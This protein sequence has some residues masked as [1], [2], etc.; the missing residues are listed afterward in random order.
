MRIRSS[1]VLNM[2]AA[3]CL[4]VSV[5]AQQP[6][7]EGADV[8]AGGWDT[9][10]ADITVRHRRL[11]RDGTPVGL[12]PMPIRYRWQQSSG[13]AGARTVLTFAPQPKA[14]AERPQDARYEVA[15][16]EDDGD[17]TPPRIYN[18]RGE[19]MQ[20]PPPASLGLSGPARPLSD[21]AARAAEGPVSLPQPPAGT[22]AMGLVAHADDVGARRS[23]LK[24][25][26]GRRVERIG[27]LERF[28]RTDGDDTE[29]V[30]A[31]PESGLPTEV[32]IVRNGRLAWHGRFMYT[33]DR[34]GAYMRRAMHIE[35]AVSDSGERVATDVELTNVTFERRGR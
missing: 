18:R 11:D 32:N 19:L 34:R 9:L 31:D 4:A 2:A 26:Y 10:S 13:P 23:R 8:E 15:R 30:L 22:L 5:N 12:E 6:A 25:R 7:R 17:G 3:V 28:V 29:E 1:P 16:I 33:R 24:E 35:H 27:R 21:E 14:V 20:L